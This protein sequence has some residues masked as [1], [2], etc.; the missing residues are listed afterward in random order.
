MNKHP[1]KYP[2]NIKKEMMARYKAGESP[3][4]LAEELGCSTSAIHYWARKENI[5]TDR[6]YHFGKEIKDAAITRY[7][8]GGSPTK[9]AFDIGCHPRSIRKWVT[10]AGF[11]LQQPRS[12]KRY[13]EHYHTEAVKRYASGEAANSIASDIGCAERTVEKW[14]RDAG[15][16]RKGGGIGYIVNPVRLPTPPVFQR[17][18]PATKIVS[19][20]QP[21]AYEAVKMAFQQADRV[22]DL[23][24]RLAGNCAEIKD[25]QKQ[26]ATAHNTIRLQQSTVEAEKQHALSYRLAVQQGDVKPPKERI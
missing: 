19:V 26:L 15:I 7:V 21:D 10:L 9:I 25:L 6:M 4:K 8:A 24:S 23:E 3:G 16:L 13:S 18:K 22:P 17:S 1:N 12:W 5:T 2:E 14:V 20:T 11:P